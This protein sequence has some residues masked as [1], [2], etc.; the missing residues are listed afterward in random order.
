MQ[1]NNGILLSLPELQDCENPAFIP[2]FIGEMPKEVRF[3]TCDYS[4]KGCNSDNLCNN[5]PR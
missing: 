4:C 2:F 3:V 1:E 5:C